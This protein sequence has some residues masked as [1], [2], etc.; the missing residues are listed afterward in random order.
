MADPAELGAKAH[1]IRG[2]LLMAVLV[3]VAY[4]LLVRELEFLVDDAFIN[5]RYAKNL[6][7]GHGLR[8]NLGESPPVEAYD[9]LWTLLMAIPELFRW[10]TP[11]LSKLVTVS[12]GATL[13]FAIARTAYRRSGPDLLVS[14]ATVMLVA[15][16]PIFAAWSTS[17]METMPAA[18]LVFAVYERLLADPDR[19]RGWQ[20]GMFAVAAALMRPD[21]FVMTGTVIFAAGLSAWMFRE[22]KLRKAVLRAACLLVVCTVLHTCWRLWYHGDWISNPTRIKGEF[23]C[24]SVERGYEY[25][26]SLLLAFPGLPLA[27]LPVLLAVLRG[28]R[29]EWFPLIVIC[30]LLVT[31]VI[32]AGGDWMPMGRFLVVV[33]PFFALL[34]AHGLASM[35]RRGV[36]RV[37]IPSLAASCIGLS[38][39]SAFDL[40][41]VTK[42]VRERVNFRWGLELT[43]ERAELE[44][45]RR[46]VERCEL[47]S[48]AT[49]LFTHAGESMIRGGIGVYGYRTDLE[50]L[51]C[52][53]LV[54]PEVARRPTPPGR[55]AR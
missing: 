42:T 19:P 35:L 10:N 41:I 55:R 24:L 9:L 34:F 54:D 50:L 45:S 52:F 15:T 13:V 26:A 2:L 18:L 11:E 33:V 39:P 17:G 16:L 7:R 51:D 37:W 44:T 4:F 8:F 30:F 1:S 53:G 46:L 29:R 43:S 14:G 20:A 28:E 22:S 27:L 3:G 5:F 12:C 25:V 31:V 47:E 6:A 36:R 48:R 49:A 40:H 32:T 21:G 23:S 38:L